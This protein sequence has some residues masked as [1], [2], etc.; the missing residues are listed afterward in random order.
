[1]QQIASSAHLPWMATELTT[2]LTLSVMLFKIR[3]PSSHILDTPLTS[4]SL[5]MSVYLH[6]FKKPMAEQS[7]PTHA[8][9]EPVSPRSCFLASIHGPS[10][11]HTLEQTSKQ[12][13]AQL[14]SSPI[15]DAVLQPLPQKLKQSWDLRKSSDGRYVQ[16]PTITPLKSL[17]W[18]M[19]QNCHQLHHQTNAVIDILAKTGASAID[20]IRKL[21]ICAPNML[22]S[23]LG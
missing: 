14:K 3:S 13:G 2:A 23:R 12:L 18:Q 21:S 6:H 22:G 15:P 1:M 16:C 19:L 5:S 11:L 20:L 10:R 8:K 4:Y 17:A 7:I 9:L